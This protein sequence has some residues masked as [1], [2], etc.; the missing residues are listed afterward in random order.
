MFGITNENDDL[1]GR[2]QDGRSLFV[3]D[4]NYIA[5]IKCVAPSVKRV[6]SKNDDVLDHRGRRNET[7]KYF[8]P[9]AST[10]P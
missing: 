5:K 10:H 9:V 4:F 7:T 8:L 2:D 1:R 3:F 6:F